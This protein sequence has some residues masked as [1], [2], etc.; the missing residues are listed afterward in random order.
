MA[1]GPPART[2]APPDKVGGAVA[3]VYSAR[4]AVVGT[5]AHSGRVF[6]RSG[7][8]IGTVRSD[9]QI[10]TPQ[11]TALAHASPTGQLTD[12]HGGVV[13]QVLP[14]GWVV[15]SLGCQVGRVALILTVSLQQ[16]AG[17]AFLLL[18]IEAT[19]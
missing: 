6:N 9:G 8:H 12:Q 1:K 4:Q 17:A 15:N 7:E 5:V 16:V 11:G 3:G 19:A 2:T 14:H 13:G 18:P 10:C